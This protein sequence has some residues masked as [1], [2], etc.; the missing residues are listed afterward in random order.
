MGE[1]LHKLLE[2][3][4]ELMRKLGL[5][6]RYWLNLLIE[7]SYP[8]YPGNLGALNQVTSYQKNNRL[9]TGYSEIL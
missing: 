4:G 5:L 2:G 3:P 9:K 7:D 1:G 8:T 6:I